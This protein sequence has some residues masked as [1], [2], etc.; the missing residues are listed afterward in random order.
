M[1]ARN[2]ASRRSH[3]KNQLVMN[4]LRK[5]TAYRVAQVTMQKPFQTTSSE[6]VAAEPRFAFDC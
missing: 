4:P 1:V 3:F 2:H 6:V 5:Q